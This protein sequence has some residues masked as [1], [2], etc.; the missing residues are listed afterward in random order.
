MGAGTDNYYWNIRGMVL[1]VAFQCIR[2]FFSNIRA[3]FIEKVNHSL[4][5]EIENCQDTVQRIPHNFT[6]NT[7]EL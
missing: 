3:Y 1:A 6:Q 5:L 2:H 7:L 4:I